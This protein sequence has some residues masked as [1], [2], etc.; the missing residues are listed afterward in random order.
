[1]DGSAKNIN[2][3]QAEDIYWRHDLTAV[4]AW[5]TPDNINTL[6]QQNGF[7][8]EVGLLHI[9][10]DGPDYWV[11]KAIDC[12]SPVIT[13][14]EYDHL[15]EPNLP[16]VQPLGEKATIGSSLLSL[17]DLAEEKGYTFIGCESHGVNAYFIRKDKLKALRALTAAEGYVRASV[18][19]HA[20]KANA[21]KGTTAFNTRIQRKEM[22]G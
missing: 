21:L 12:I 19:G 18:Q 3:L 9:D 5:I 8:G 16:Y 20:V 17:C 10:I 14:V 7:T 11:W 13:I 2:Q 22:I 15:A 1:M 6:L 4:S